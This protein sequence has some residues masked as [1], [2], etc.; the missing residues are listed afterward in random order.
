MAEL[1]GRQVYTLFLTLALGLNYFM[2]SSLLVDPPSFSA[3]ADNEDLCC[4]SGRTISVVM[5]GY[6]YWIMGH[7]RAHR[8]V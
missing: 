5:G 1:A 6:F 8:R 2:R 3:L 7:G 4:E